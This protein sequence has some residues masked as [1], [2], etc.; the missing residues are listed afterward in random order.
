MK[1]EDYS[2]YLNHALWRKKRDEVFS[3]LGRTCSKC[4]SDINLE[5]HHKTY[6]LDKMPWEYPLENFVVLCEKCHKNHHG[7]EYTY[8]KCKRCGK[9][10]STK[11]YYCLPCHNRLIEE[12]ETEKKNL[13][14]KIAE[15]KDL[16]N[17]ESNVKDDESPNKK[18]QFK[19][20]MVLLTKEKNSLEKNL[21]K[22]RILDGKFKE[23]IKT[24]IKSLESKIDILQVEKNNNNNASEEKQKQLEEE[25][26]RL[27]NEMD[28]LNKTLEESKRVDEFKETIKANNQKLESK[29]NLLIKGLVL[30]AAIILTTI[31]VLWFKGFPT[32]NTPAQIP[33][34]TTTID[35]KEKP[36]VND[37]VN[38]PFQDKKNKTLPRVETAN[39]PI[40][41]DEAKE[42]N[43]NEKNDEVSVSLQIPQSSYK[44]IS[45]DEVYSNL[46]NKVQITE[47]IFQVIETKNG[48]VYLNIGGKYPVNKLSAVIFENNIGNFGEL[49]KYENKLVKIKGTLSNYKGRA[50]IIINKQ[51]QL[52][53]IE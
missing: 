27:K 3:K 36:T 11:F 14:D 12:K 50:E 15:L 53:E 23:E 7:I 38:N 41:K 2:T 42:S 39:A 52:Q 37:S 45:I 16:L 35:K 44:I 4:S 5:I 46:G 13:E 6:S 33:K 25:I 48:Q 49:K 32:N 28:K 22:L 8:N 51:W 26:E 31:F 10:I 29:I 17:R 47:K 19:K 9:E 43:K 34:D 21:I 18:E 24:D 40:K 30:F 1:K 20:D